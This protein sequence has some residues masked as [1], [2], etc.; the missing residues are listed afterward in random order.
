MIYFQSAEP[1]NGEAAEDGAVN[2]QPISVEVIVNF[3]VSD[4]PYC[5]VIDVHYD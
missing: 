3:F 5:M 1:S 2:P 4:Y